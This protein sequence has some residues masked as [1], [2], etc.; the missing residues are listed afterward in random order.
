[1]PS[2]KLM[3]RMQNVGVTALLR[4]SRANNS[5]KA[6]EAYLV[7]SSQTKNSTPRMGLKTI[8]NPE[9]LHVLSNSRQDTH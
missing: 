3:G 9:V 8:R 1:M 2:R 6:R 5:K 7:E 4:I